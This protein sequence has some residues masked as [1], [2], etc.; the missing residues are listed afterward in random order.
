VLIVLLSSYLV[1]L[2]NLLIRRS[3][4]SPLQTLDTWL[5]APLNLVWSLIVLRP[6]RIYGTLTCGNNGWGTRGKIEVGIASGIAAKG[7]ALP[8][9]EAGTRR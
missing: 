9:G 2:R 8:S 3:D 4:H 7:N 6:M 5:L 1:A